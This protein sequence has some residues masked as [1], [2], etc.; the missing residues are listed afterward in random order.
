MSSMTAPISVGLA[1]DVT[2]KGTD[3]LDEF[4]KDDSI[5]TACCA[6]QHNIDARSKCVL[7]VEGLC[8]RGVCQFLYKKE[9]S[10]WVGLY[11]LYSGI[12][13]R[14]NSNVIAGIILSI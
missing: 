8:Q 13:F 6:K 5:S 12:N 2:D 14:V 11:C 9:Q 10:V 1:A 7:I 4:I 3:D